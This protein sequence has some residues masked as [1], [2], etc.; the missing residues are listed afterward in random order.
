MDDPDLHFRM[1]A[2]K[3]LLQKPVAKTEA[4]VI[5][6]SAS[7]PSSRYRHNL[8]ELLA[9]EYSDVFIHPVLLQSVLD[10]I[11]HIVTDHIRDMV[12]SEEVQ[13]VIEG[14][15]HICDNR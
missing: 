1:I 15:L 13:R 11:D 10:A 2:N 12:V 14:V 9:R 6:T 8:N 7:V 3:R 5:D 4:V